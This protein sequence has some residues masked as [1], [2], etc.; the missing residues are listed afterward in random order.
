M[1]QRIEGLIAAPFT[2]M[3]SDGGVNLEV[4]EKQA[5]FLHRNGC[6]GAFVCGTTGEG[7]SLTVQERT[8]I[9]RRWVETAPDGFRVIVHVGHTSLEVSRRLAAHAQTIGAWGVGA[10]GPFFY[11]PQTVED[12]AAFCAEIAAA[13]P[14]LPFYYYHIPSMTGISF[15]MVTFLEAAAPRIPNLGGLKYTYEDMMDFE[16][17]R[18]FD[19]GRF[20]MLFGRDEILICALALGGRAA[21]GSTYNFAAPLYVRL[22]EAF[23]AGDLATARSLQDQSID[24]VQTLLTAPC[25]FMA[26]AKS[27]MKMLGIDC[28][29]TRPPLRPITDDQYES[30][31]AGLKAIGF[32]D[33]CAK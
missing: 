17:C 11:K 12:L 24:T 8:D 30:L 20:D 27:V 18:R 13:A 3:D 23:G 26:A 25:G 29:P 10:M 2:P 9:A 21:V 5:Q 33:Y 22:M 6:Q 4:I 28:G 15:P 19:G 31:Q 14:Q 32:F 7:M 16:L 1:N